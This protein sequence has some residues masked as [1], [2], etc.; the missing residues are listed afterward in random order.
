MT[1]EKAL[2]KRKISVGVRVHA[3]EKWKMVGRPSKAVKVAARLPVVH[4]VSCYQ[5]K[6]EI[7]TET[8]SVISQN[9]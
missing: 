3:R 6:T 5:R 1:M 2:P 9:T 4:S 7:N 8:Y